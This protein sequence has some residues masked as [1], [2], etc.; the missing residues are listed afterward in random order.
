MLILVYITA[1]SFNNSGIV[2]EDISKEFSELVNEAIEFENKG[3]IDAAIETYLKMLN[4]LDEEKK[5]NIS[6][7]YTATALRIA[8]LYEFEKKFDKSLA[9]YKEL[10]EMYLNVIINEENFDSKIGKSTYDTALLCS[11]AI[12]SRY[13]QLLPKTETSKAKEILLINIVQAHRRIIL[14]YAPFLSVL[15]DI[16][17]RNILSLI[18]TDLEKELDKLDEIHKELKLKEA[19]K[20]P[21]ELPL[22]STDRS[23]NHSK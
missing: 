20:N 14:N 1:D 19:S 10:S 12:A 18:S 23:V 6:F 22:Y 21:L 11:L 3:K 13:A 2:I 5:E 4:Q 8:Q 9:I 15:N 7:N 16:T 17:N